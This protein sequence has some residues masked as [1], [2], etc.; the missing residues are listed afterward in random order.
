MLR[1]FDGLE[2]STDRNLMQS[3][4]CKVMHLGKNNPRHQNML[5]GDHLE[6]NLSEKDLG[7]VVDTKL[8]MS[9]QVRLLLIS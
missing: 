9:E 5:E 4:N 3:N 6:R 1:D 8:N 2:K 7:L